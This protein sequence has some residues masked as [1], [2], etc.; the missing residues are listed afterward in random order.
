MLRTLYALSFCAF[1]L[2]LAG[3]VAAQSGQTPANIPTI[4]V[5]SRLVFLDVTV[6][7]K[8][9]HPVATGLTKDDFVITEEKRPQRIFSF[10]EPN[11]HVAD[12]ALSE[13]N[14][15]GKAPMTIFVLDLLNSGFAD[16]AFI[17]YSI[18][19]Y[20]AAQPDPLNSPAELMVLG[21][22][23]LE[24][25]QG[26]TRSKEDLLSALDH[27]PAAVPYKFMNGAFF[28]ERFGQSIDA[29]QQIALQNKGLP[30]RKNIVWVGHGGPNIL[31]G[32]LGGPVVDDLNQYVRDT[33]NMLV[34][35]RVSLFVIYPGLK[36]TSPALT[37]SEGSA[38]ADIGD[39]DP[40]AG[41]INFGVF[42][43]ET[44]GKLF[45]NRNDV[46]RE[47]E[48][49]EELG[50]EYYTLTYQPEGGRAD[51]KFRRIRVTM[52]DPGL[53][54]L[55][56]AGYF[57]PDPRTAVDPRQQ[58]MVNLDEAAQASIPFQALDVTIEGVVRHPDTRTAAFTVVLNPRNIDWDEAADGK[59]TANLALAAMSLS[60]S[61]DIL[62]SKR[63]TVTVTVNTKDPAR[64]AATGTNLPVLIQLPPKTRNLRIAVQTVEGGRI[65]TAELDRKTIDA[66]PEV[67]TPPPKLQPRSQVQPAPAPGVN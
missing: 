62:A 31:T 19:K 23:S 55:T 53:R 28:A 35:S 3:T 16:S 38:V 20:L 29:L 32:V 27:V 46:N 63:E 1:S 57:A 8:K 12:R 58:T 66:A 40:F 60:E 47:V 48:Q 42:V 44:G 65:G 7:D 41:D 37:F 51:G 67:P 50:S 4:Q 14:P 11:V 6:L 5:T 26:Y 9:G 22:Q 21:N 54:A 39:N 30:G 45:Y 61:G 52:R 33:T 36:I 59:S 24:M 18:R 13:D 49:S 64:L 10:E 34:D 43:N 25:A 56:K 17:R 15:S 2:G